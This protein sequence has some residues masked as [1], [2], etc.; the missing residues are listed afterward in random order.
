[1]PD[2]LKNCDMDCDV[3][4]PKDADLLRSIVIDRDQ[5][6]LVSL[7]KGPVS[8]DT[9]NALCVIGSVNGMPSKTT[10]HEAVRLKRKASHQRSVS[11]VAA[12]LLEN[13]R[14]GKGL[15]RCLRG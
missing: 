4:P 12:E 7:M 6:L 5:P 15:S 14:T 1:M 13:G 2:R 3:S 8:V 10:P 11:Q 9:T